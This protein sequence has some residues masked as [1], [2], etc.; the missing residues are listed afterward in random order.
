MILLQK[1]NWCVYNFTFTETTSP[2]LFPLVKCEPDG[3]KITFGCLAH[4]NYP[5][6]LTFQWTN[7]CGADLTSDQYPSILNN[8]KYT[9]VSL[10][11]V[12][13]SDWNLKHSFECSVTHAGGSRSVTLGKSMWCFIY[14]HSSLSVCLRVNMRYSSSFRQKMFFINYCFIC[15]NQS[16]QF[17][18]QVLNELLQTD[19]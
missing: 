14:N 7:A 4:Y 15:L 3:D 8:N 1:S 9:G 10:L 11:K 17:Y 12:P 5:K 19:L 2:T 18:I 13:K 16:D 6:S